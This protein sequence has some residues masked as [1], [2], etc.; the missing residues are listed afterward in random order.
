M[1]LYEQVPTFEVAQ[2][3]QATPE[4]NSGSCFSRTYSRVAAAY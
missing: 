2:S 4:G 3:T 1:R